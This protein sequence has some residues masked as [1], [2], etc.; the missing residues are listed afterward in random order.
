MSSP[1]PSSLVVAR[2]AMPAPGTGH[3]AVLV[4]DRGLFRFVG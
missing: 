1:C 4:F 2:K 3:P